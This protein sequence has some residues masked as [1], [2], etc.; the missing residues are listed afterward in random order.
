MD[1]EKNKNKNRYT[2]T[3]KRKTVNFG[4]QR[5]TLGIKMCLEMKKIVQEM[6]CS[7][8]HDAI[9]HTTKI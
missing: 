5:N 6:F 4:S 7:H 8:F 3:L 2:Y 1:K 9:N